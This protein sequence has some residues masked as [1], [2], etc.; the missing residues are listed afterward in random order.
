MTK[1]I[2][3]VKICYKLLYVI[4][5]IKRFLISIT[6][7]PQLISKFLVTPIYNAASDWPRTFLDPGCFCLAYL[8]SYMFSIEFLT[9]TFNN[10]FDCFINNVCKQCYIC[11]IRFTKTVPI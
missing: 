1:P 2:L 11:V 3:L 5:E 6:S 7:W 10:D 8:Y 4:K 9:E